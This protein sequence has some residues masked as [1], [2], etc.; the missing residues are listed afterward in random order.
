M[1][2]DTIGKMADATEAVPEAIGQAIEATQVIV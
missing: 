1:D 2:P